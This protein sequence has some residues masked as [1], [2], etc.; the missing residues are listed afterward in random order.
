[1]ADNLGWGYLGYLGIALH[2]HSFL[3]GA[4]TSLLSSELVLKRV[5]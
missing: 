4:A 2:T 1:M 5:N 3:L